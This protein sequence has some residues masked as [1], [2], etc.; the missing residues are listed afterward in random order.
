M[1][2]KKYLISL[3]IIFSCL[4]G[5]SIFLT[6]FNYFDIINFNTFKILKVITSIVS[7]FIGGFI[8]GKKSDKKGFLEG[9]KLGVIYVLI[10]FILSICLSNFKI[11]KLLLYFMLILTSMLGSMF[12]INKNTKE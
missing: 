3:G 5:I 9:I 1:N 7:L 6:I 2:I 4:L 10:I 12:G 11:S 8:I